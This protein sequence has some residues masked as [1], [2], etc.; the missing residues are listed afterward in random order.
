[1]SR[2]TCNSCFP[3]SQWR[4]H[5]PTA[6]QSQGASACCW[7]PA[8]ASGTVR[9]GSKRFRPELG[10]T[11]FPQVE[12]KGPLLHTWHLNNL[13]VKRISSSGFKDTGLEWSFLQSSYSIYKEGS[14]WS[15]LSLRYRLGVEYKF[16]TTHFFTSLF[17]CKAI[18]PSTLQYEKS[19]SFWYIS[20]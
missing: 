18:R 16:K 17:W 3:H 12:K 11:H 14:L 7:L 19:V 2:V 5:R 20:T 10:K 6:T 1:M 15:Q 4:W 13:R 8:H 9:T